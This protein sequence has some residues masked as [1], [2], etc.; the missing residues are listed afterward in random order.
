MLKLAHCKNIGLFY[1]WEPVFVDMEQR[2][3]VMSVGFLLTNRNDAVI[4]RGP[5]KNG[6]FMSIYY[7]IFY[8]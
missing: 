2:L 6:M 5:K 8:Y 3:C 1:S 4:L 7:Y